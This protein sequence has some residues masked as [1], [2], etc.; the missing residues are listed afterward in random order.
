MLWHGAQLEAEAVLAA[1]KKG[2]IV[3]PRVGEFKEE[4]EIK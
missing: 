1:E 4:I 3:R 2:M